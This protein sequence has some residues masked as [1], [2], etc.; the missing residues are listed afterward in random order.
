MRLSELGELGL[1]AELERRGLAREIEH[2]AAQLSGG[3]VVTN[4]VLVQEVHFRLEWTS[5]RDLGYRAAAVNLSDLAA[6]GAEPEGLIVGLGAPPETPLE[7]VIE[8][9]EGLNEPGVPILGGDTT[10]SERLFLS[11]TALGRSERVPGRAGARPGDL[12]VV[13]G[14][15][16][17]AGAAFREQRHS[18]PPLRLDEG[19][20]LA[21][22]A[23]ALIDLSDGLARDA[24]H[25]ARRSGCRLA[26]EL[27]RVPLAQ[28]AAI[29]DLGFGED[30]ELLAATPTRS[31]R[32]DRP[33]CRGRGRRAPA[34]GRGRRARRL[35]TLHLGALSGGLLNRPRAGN[36]LGGSASLVLKRLAWAVVVFLAVTFST[37][38]LFFVIPTNRPGSSNVQGPTSPRA[39]TRRP[40]STARSGTSTA[41]SSG[42][43]SPSRAW[44]ARRRAARR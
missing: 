12:L 29:A 2:D 18:R 31:I 3:R 38:V 14:P 36:V 4:D 17:A 41:C 43:S 10:A 35:G 9:Y 20:R 11:V 16:G 6:S 24:G 33:L 34:R 1:L 7:D 44:D 15:L 32:R 23:N 13:T 21:A 30:Y 39:S 42:G 28:G 25:I 5:Y 19:R 26:I 40:A 37:Y 8:L 22:S 27:E